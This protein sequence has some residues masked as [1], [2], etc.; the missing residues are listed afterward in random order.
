MST[1]RR[2]RGAEGGPRPPAEADAPTD[3]L[4]LDERLKLREA[5]FRDAGVDPRQFLQAF[6]HVPGLFYFVKDA[7]SRTMLNTREYTR[8]MGY[9]PDDEIVGKRA[10]EYLARDLADHYEADD[11][12]VLRTGQPLRN[13]IEI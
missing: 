1:K 3:T 12:K 10:R 8:R 11:Q 9:Q 13:I 4:P 7:E 2:T 6:D 5:F